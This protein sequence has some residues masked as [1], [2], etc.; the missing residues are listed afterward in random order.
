MNELIQELTRLES[1]LSLISKI[2]YPLVGKTPPANELADQL[3]R[4]VG[5]RMGAI[6]FDM[7]MHE[8]LCG[9]SAPAHTDKDGTSYY[10]NRH[11]ELQGTYL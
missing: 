3:A 5:E 2:Q 11:D 7:R 10:Y 9:D 8:H 6:K 4:M 1:M